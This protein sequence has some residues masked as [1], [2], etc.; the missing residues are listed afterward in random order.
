MP[1]RNALATNLSKFFRTGACRSIPRH[2]ARS[3]AT[4]VKPP[5]ADDL[6]L[7]DA[8]GQHQTYA[9]TINQP[10]GLFGHAKLTTPPELLRLAQ[11]TLLRAELLV[12]RILRARSSNRELFQAVRNL[13]RLSDLLCGVID[14]AELVRTVHPHKAWVD[15]AEEAYDILC[16]YMNTLN[17]H[18]GLYEVGFDLFRSY[19]ISLTSVSVSGVKRALQTYRIC[20]QPRRRS[21]GNRSHFLEGL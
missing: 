7:L 16:D 15:A 19:D 8:F 12:E 11:S 4:A 5:S 17:T 2:P 1:F 10:T 9:K 20:R 21:S 6:L 13:D 3:F 14:L 18:V